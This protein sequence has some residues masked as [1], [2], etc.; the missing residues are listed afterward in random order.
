MWLAQQ[1]K[2]NSMLLCLFMHWQLCVHGN[3]MQGIPWERDCDEILKKV[4]VE[5]SFESNVSH[6][7]WFMVS[8]FSLVILVFFYFIMLDLNFC[9][10][11]CMIMPLSFWCHIVIY[12]HG[13]LLFCFLWFPFTFW[14]LGIIWERVKFMELMESWMKSSRENSLILQPNNRAGDPCACYEKFSHN[15]H[16]CPIL[17]QMC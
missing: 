17:P 10:L 16:E 1:C 12:F 13:I 5:M 15:I 3:M 4:Q 2:V 7:D 6:G 11:S 9:Y 14:D 8:I